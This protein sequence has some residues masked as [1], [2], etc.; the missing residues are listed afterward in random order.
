MYIHDIGSI[1]FLFTK[2]LKQEPA[3]IE[4]RDNECEDN[5]PFKSA[6]I[7]IRDDECEDNNPFESYELI[8]D[9]NKKNW[10]RNK[11]FWNNAESKRN[12][13]KSKIKLSQIKKKI[14][15]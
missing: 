3:E 14:K 10:A 4:I 1:S 5:N 12:K 8:E 13:R 7:E 2:D 6:D 11:L 15:N 9:Q